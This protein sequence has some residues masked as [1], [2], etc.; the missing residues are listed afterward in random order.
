MPAT[1]LRQL[2]QAPFVVGRRM[3][4]RGIR[5]KGGLL[6]SEWVRGPLH[7]PGCS[8]SRSSLFQDP[9]F[10]RSSNTCFP[11]QQPKK[12]GTQRRNATCVITT[13]LHCDYTR[14][15]SPDL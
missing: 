3:H 4:P 15:F 11:S 9:P 1:C 10:P 5:P 7:T 12:T 14:H 6:G 13:A 8:S 2:K